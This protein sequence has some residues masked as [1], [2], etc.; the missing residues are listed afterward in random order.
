MKGFKFVPFGLGLLSL[1]LIVGFSVPSPANA[2]YF[3]SGGRFQLFRG[4]FSLGS[5]EYY[6]TYSA[7]SNYLSHYTALN[8]AGDG[9][10]D[11]NSLDNGTVHGTMSTGLPQYILAD[12][13]SVKYVDHISIKDI[14]TAHPDSWGPAYTNGAT[15]FASAD[16]LS[17]TT[18]TT[19]AGMVDYAYSQF[20]VKGSYR[21]IELY[22]ATGYVALGDFRVLAR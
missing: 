7:S 15:L 10:R 14:P 16:G 4:Q 3:F 20:P 17:T 9:M 1:L 8:G 22:V 6:P 12:L 21:F 13:G 11:G 18:I 19:I 2:G 5:F